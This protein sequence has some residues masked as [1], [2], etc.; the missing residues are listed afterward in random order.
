MKTLT[1]AVKIPEE[2][3]WNP[4]YPGVEPSIHTVATGGTR[5]ID[6]LIKII[7]SL[8]INKI[9]HVAIIITSANSKCLMKM[10]LGELS[11][12]LLQR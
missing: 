10:I 12:T 9:I 4:L 8:Y 6:R 5:K 3:I 7:I 1:R 2:T 11:P